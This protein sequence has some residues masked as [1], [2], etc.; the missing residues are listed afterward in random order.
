MDYSQAALG[1]NA[2]RA[3]LYHLR[4]LGTGYAVPDVVD[5]CSFIDTT[6][7]GWEFGSA[8]RIVRDSEFRST[9]GTSLYIDTCGPQ[10]HI[11]GC[12]F[13]DSAIGFQSRHSPLGSRLLFNI[14]DTCTTRASFGNTWRYMLFANNTV[15]GCT[16]GVSIGDPDIY[17]IYGSVFLNNLFVS[18]ATGLSRTDASNDY[19][20][21]NNW[22]GNST[23]V[24]NFTK[25]THD[26]AVDPEFTDAAGGDF[27][28]AT[29]SSCIGA[30][31]SIRLGVGS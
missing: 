24:S 15:Y 27:S 3:S 10:T 4:F 8:V 13:H 26:T 25:G 30:A 23:D 5:N 17:A 31:F 7:T 16:T 20:D 11:I 28:L 9:E 2:I 1:S 6:G 12:Y 18:N 21:Y 29:G 22:Y 14:F 19:L